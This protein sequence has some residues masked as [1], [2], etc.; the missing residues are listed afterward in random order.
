MKKTSIIF[1]AAAAAFALAACDKALVE[2]APETVQPS[3]D[4]KVNI[5]V[6]DFNG[7][8][9]TKAVMK[10][11]WANGDKISI[12]YDSNTGDT[13]DLVIDYNGSTWEKSSGTTT[14]SASGTLKAVYSNNLI[15]ASNGISYTYDGSKLTANINSW[16]HLAEIQVVVSGLASADAA[17]YTLACDKF[18]PLSGNGYTVGSDAITASKGTKGAVATGIANSDGVAFVFATSDYSA[19]EQNFLFTLTKTTDALASRKVKGYSVNKTLTAST[20]AIKAI[21][22]ADTSFSE[23]VQLWSG[24]PYW[25]YNNIGAESAAGYGYY[26]AWGYTYGCVYNSSNNGWVL[27][28]DGTTVKEFYSADFP[29]LSP[30]SGKVLE[31]AKDAATQ[32]WGSGWS[33]PR[34]DDFSNLKNNCGIDCV[35]AGTKGIKITGNTDGYKDKS[36]FLPAAGNGYDFHWYNVNEGFCYYWSSV[37]YDD[38]WAYHVFIKTSGLSFTVSSNHKYLGYPVRPVRS[39]L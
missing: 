35:T 11:G 6:A 27:A 34:Y 1:A 16:N 31:A 36:I 38:D 23:A 15:V 18:T 22:I 5:T 17:N 20:S 39:S 37:M 24:G 8:S 14:P 29:S 9:D 33:M 13:P 25:A 26:F 4:I 7:S 32:N 10:T 12:W 2:N 30:A 28:S 19:S 3:G 21:S